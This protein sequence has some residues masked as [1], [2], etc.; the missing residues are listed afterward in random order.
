VVAPLVA[1]R[2]EAGTT[3]FGGTRRHQMPLDR[4]VVRFP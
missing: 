3:Q 4:S 2:Q 1:G